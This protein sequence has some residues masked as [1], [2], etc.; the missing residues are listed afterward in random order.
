MDNARRQLG[1]AAAAPFSGRGVRVAVLDTGI[2]LRHPDLSGR[3]NAEL[4]QSVS[5]RGDIEDR[6]GH[7]SHIAGIIGG[8]GSASNGLYRGVA[9]ECE[10]IVLKIAEQ[11][12]APEGNA[13]AAIAAAIE[14]KVDIINYSHGHVPAVGA[15]P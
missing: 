9:P 11:H 12:K 6:N 13:A 1:L 2:D 15:A 4:S 10:L 8:T 7:G 14:A 5:S 3:I